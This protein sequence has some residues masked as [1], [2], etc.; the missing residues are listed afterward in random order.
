MSDIPKLYDIHVE[1]L[2]K[3]GYNNLKE[4]CETEG[5]IY[6]GRAHGCFVNKKPYPEKDSIFANRFSVKKYGLY[7]CLKLYVNNLL[8]KMDKNEDL[9]HELMSLKGKN[10]GCWCVGSKFCSEITEDF[11]CHGQILQYLIDYFDN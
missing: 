11:I 6:I 7:E 8:D 1:F 10:I 5:N 2:R 4:W 9:Y 3:Q